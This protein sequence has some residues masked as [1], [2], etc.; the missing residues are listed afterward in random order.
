MK[1]YGI[2]IL[3]VIL[4][5]SFIQNA[6]AAL[7]TGATLFDVNVP[8]LCGGATLAITAINFQSTQVQSDYVLTYQPPDI[9]DVLLLPQ[10]PIIEEN[11][12]FFPRTI[13]DDTFVSRREGGRFHS[14]PSGSDWGYKLEVGYI[15]PCSGNNLVFSY[16]HYHNSRWVFTRQKHHKILIPTLSNRWP[17]VGSVNIVNPNLSLPFITLYQPDG[18]LPL[19][20]EPNVA[21]A[22]ANVHYD[23]FD[24]DFGQSINLGCR[25]RIKCFGGL[26]YANL[27]NQFTV[28]YSYRS[29]EPNALSLAGLSPAS[30]VKIDLSADYTETIFQTSKYGGVGPHVGVDA[31]YHM[32]WGFGIVSS[33]SASV[34]TGETNTIVERTFKKLNVATL[35]ER[36]NP[37]SIFAT[38]FVF[39]N[40]TTQASYFKY[41]GELRVVPNLDAKLGF[42]YSY[43]WCKKSHTKVNLEVGYRISQYFHVI[44]RIFTQNCMENPIGERGSIN[45]HFQGF[46][47]GIQVNT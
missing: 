9:D 16:L 42:D 40:R 46:Y 8:S 33:L 18:L 15:F 34:L 35:T 31:V 21:T 22:E 2:G 12:F 38:P 19:P 3:G 13:L 36:D 47:L 29:S 30:Q 11:A 39:L 14:V 6:L 4:T 5:V 24:F 44:D 7:P 37:N 23:V 20:I 41:P 43:Q 17:T 1:S 27:N 32:A 25:T 45:Q 10:R 26:R 28:I